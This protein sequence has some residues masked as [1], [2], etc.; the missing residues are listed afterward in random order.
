MI[1]CILTKYGAYTDYNCA[2][3][4]HI[5]TKNLLTE[6]KQWTL[7]MDVYRQFEPITCVLSQGEFDN[8]SK[9]D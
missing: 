7:L 8:I 1:C 4:V 9:E 3:Q 6:G 2:F 5:G